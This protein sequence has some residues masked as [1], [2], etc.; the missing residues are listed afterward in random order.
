MASDTR[1]VPDRPRRM[2]PLFI[3]LFMTEDEDSDQHG[4]RRTRRNKRVLKA[5]AVRRLK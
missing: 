3:Q 1:H 2:H 5:R 4:E